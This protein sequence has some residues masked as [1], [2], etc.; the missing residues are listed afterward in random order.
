MSFSHHGKVWKAETT[1]EHAGNIMTKINA[2]LQE[3]GVVD[4]NGKPVSLLP[5]FASALYLLVLGSANAIADYDKKLTQAKNSFNIEL[6]DDTQIQN[7]LPIAAV[8]R[9]AGTKS[10]IKLEFSALESADCIVPK[11]TKVPYET[12]NFVVPTDVVI[13][14]GETKSVIAVC[15][16]VGAVTVLVGE[17]TAVEGSI[18]NLKKVINRES[19]VPGKD[20]ESVNDLRQ[21]LISGNTIKYSLGGCIIAISNL[22][23]V[24]YARVYFNYNTSVPMT[25]E[26]GVVVKPRHAYIVI[27]GTSDKL[28]ETYASY[29]N[30]P[31]HN[32][33]GS[34]EQYQV[35]VTQ[36]GQ[37][38]KIFY[39]SAKEHQVY[40]KI[41]LEET[42]QEGTHIENQL[43]K[44][45]ITSSAYWSIGLPITQLLTSV[46]FSD[47]TYAKVAYTQVS[48]DGS[49]WKSVISVPAN[50]VPRLSDT[51]ITVEKL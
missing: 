37:E 22:T 1:Q 34:A 51:H 43:K 4:G 29:M 48:T 46:P 24:S 38:M 14:K 36:S 32:A 23:G 44:D 15:D 7:L 27:H 6:C 45:L 50:V 9:G 42:S 25:L 49:A 11:G 10:T 17:I 31:T 40:V 5:S 19:S 12:V 39:D 18:P 30:A 16:A 13:P 41:V 3:Q 47:I 28:A 2:L 26:G 33:Q 35:Y 8:E 20:P 21:R